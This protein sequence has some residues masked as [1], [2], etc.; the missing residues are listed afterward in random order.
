MLGLALAVTA[1][2]FGA[3]VLF[4]CFEFLKGSYRL[5]MIIRYIM[6]VVCGMLISTAFSL[7]R[8]ASAVLVDKNVNALLSVGIVLA[9]LIL[10]LFL[11]RKFRFNDLALLAMGGV[12]TILALGLVDFLT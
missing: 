9:L 2:A 12:G 3:L 5:Q 8:Q 4:L 11:H 1:T 7:L 10:M 6:P